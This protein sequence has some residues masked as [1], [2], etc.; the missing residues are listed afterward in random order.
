MNQPLLKALLYFCAAARY[1]SFKRAAATTVK[2][3]IL[4]SFA[5]GRSGSGTDGPPIVG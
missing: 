3:W 2:Q 1:R 5:I 4:E